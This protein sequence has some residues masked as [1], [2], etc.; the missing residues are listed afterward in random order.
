VSILWGA[1]GIA[2]GE[3]E[4]GRLTAWNLGVNIISLVCSNKGFRSELKLKRCLRRRQ[5]PID[6]KN[7]LKR[8]KGLRER[9]LG[10]L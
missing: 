2:T 9:T 4:A 10:G 6:L 3:A 7:N 5:C 1:G 8:W